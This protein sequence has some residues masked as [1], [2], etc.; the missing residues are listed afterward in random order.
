MAAL[1]LSDQVRKRLNAL[2]DDD[3]F[4]SEQLMARLRE[5]RESEGIQAY[6]G[7]LHALAH[8][9]I[10]EVQAERLL[11]DLLR[12]RNEVKR[13]LG[14]DPGLRVAAIDYLSNVKKML[15]NPT[16]VENAHLEQTERSAITDPLTRLY[17]RRFFSRAL[18]LEVRRSHRYGLRMSLLMLDLD[19]FK[20][21]NDRHGHL[22][23]DLVLKRVARVFRRT[24]R[25]ADT[26]CRYGGEEFSV[27]L[28]E[29]DRLG[30]YALAER[31]R[32]GVRRSFSRKPVG[33][34]IV[35]VTLSGGI[36]SYPVDGEEPA[37]LIARADQALYLA[38]R[39]GKD[40]I[41]L[42]HSERRH[43]IRYPAKPTAWASLT[44][45]AGG[46]GEK[47][48]PLNLSRGGAL[49]DLDGELGQ[50]ETVQLKF[51]GHD[52][53]GRARYW[54]MDAQVVRV[55]PRPTAGQPQRV[56]V[57]FDGELPEDCLQQQ[58]QR[59]RALAA[60]EGGRA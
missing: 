54:V 24:V 48:R 31:I 3:R 52:P 29:T 2:L 19:E 53:A 28:P 23:G 50:S 51:D 45:A 9:E 56:A 58:V 10:P 26:A 38:K 12:H 14:R 30:G 44:R 57:A 55:E 20:S 49:L 25:D 15:V 11:A 46:T 5:L 8:L 16:I 34:K 4:D 41:S 27:I 42:Y 59:T 39:C 13:A 6:S 21:L 36:A 18:T 17:N 1:R 60:A 40:Q 32:T 33:G 47:A 43:A 37:A 22:F 35:S 7:A